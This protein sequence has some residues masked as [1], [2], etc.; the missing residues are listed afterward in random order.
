MRLE[1]IEE[2]KVLNETAKYI[3]VGEYKE[4]TDE[5]FNCSLYSENNTLLAQYRYFD[6]FDIPKHKIIENSVE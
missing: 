4:E 1:L 2:Y 5:Y 3:E 6:N